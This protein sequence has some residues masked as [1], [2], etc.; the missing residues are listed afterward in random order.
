M[1]ST[2]KALVLALDLAQVPAFARELRQQPLPPDVL[3]VIRIAADS[4]R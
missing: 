4:T 1:Q 2:P 3:D